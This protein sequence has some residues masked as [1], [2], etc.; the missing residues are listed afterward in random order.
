MLGRQAY[1]AALFV[2]FGLITWDATVRGR[3][4]TQPTRPTSAHELSCDLTKAGSRSSQLLGKLPEASGLT[5][6][7]RSPNL[8]W[9]MNDS[10][11]R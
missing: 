3:S 2:V 9:S 8:L 5:L 10:T 6:S 7:R 1:F 11:T 4:S